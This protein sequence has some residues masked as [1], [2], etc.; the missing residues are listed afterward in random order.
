MA[1][2]ATVGKFTTIEE[3][4]WKIV[5]TIPTGCKRVDLVADNYRKAPWKN[6]TC[7]DRDSGE[8]IIIKSAKSQIRDWQSFMKCSNSKTQMINIMFRYIQTVRLK[9]KVRTTIMYLSQ[10]NQCC[11]VTLSSQNERVEELVSS[12]EE[13]DYRLLVKT[14]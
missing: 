7:K 3:L 1:A 2:I 6:S 10:E 11:S 13:T 9:S 8:E 5:N 12:Y 4:T 14:F